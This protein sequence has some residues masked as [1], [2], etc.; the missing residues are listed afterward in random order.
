MHS[1]VLAT[2][3][4]GKVVEFQE[5]FHQANIHGLEIETLANYSGYESPVEDAPDFV[6][7]A[8]IKAYHAAQVTGKPAMADDSGLTCHALGDKPGVHTARFAAMH[9]Y[10]NPE[11]KD[12]DQLNWQCLLDQ[13]QA[14]STPEERAAYFTCAIV[15]VRYPND[16]APVI[17][18][19]TSDGYITFAPQGE[20]GHGYDPVFFSTPLQKTFAQATMEEKNSVSHRGRAFASFIRHAQQLGLF[21]A[22]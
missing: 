5:L 21:D 11:C 15:Y 1:I 8:L 17:G 4:Q 6:G 18:I 19:G 7:N 2:S 12:K 20:H 9:N 3:N 16:P 14:Y 22:Q 13:L 10:I